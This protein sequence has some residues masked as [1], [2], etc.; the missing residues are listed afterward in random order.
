MCLTAAVILAGCSTVK[1]PINKPEKYFLILGTEGAMATMY[2]CVTELNPE[3][4]L[5]VIDGWSMHYPSDQ[6]PTRKNMLRTLRRLAKQVDANDS[7]YVFVGRGVW[8]KG[9]LTQEELDSLLDKIRPEDG[10]QFQMQSTTRC[11]IRKKSVGQGW[12]DW[13]RRKTLNFKHHS[14]AYRERNRRSNQRI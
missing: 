10:L 14:P 3:R 9:L 12:Y 6:E 1:P 13:K 7:F 8:N 5:T 4:H 11:Y 2:N